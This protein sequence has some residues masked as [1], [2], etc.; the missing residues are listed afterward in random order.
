MLL[1][2]IESINFYL[3]PNIAALYFPSSRLWKPRPCQWSIPHTSPRPWSQ[4]WTGLL[5]RPRNG[6]PKCA[7]CGPK[8]CGLRLTCGSARLRMRLGLGWF[9]RSS[10]PFRICMCLRWGWLIVLECQLG[11]R[12]V[13][14]RFGCPIFCSR[15]C[16]C[17]EELCRRSSQEGR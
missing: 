11:R 10:S 5:P 2:W 13:R 7:L 4:N 14:W 9:P 16:R 1:K 8:L 6:T 12:W 15:D 3:L 17:R